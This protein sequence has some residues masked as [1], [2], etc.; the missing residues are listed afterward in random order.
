M[1]STVDKAQQEAISALERLIAEKEREIR[2]IAAA[3]SQL[4]GGSAV[5]VEP[6]A[7]P[8]LGEY[9]GLGIVEAAE[10]WL[11]EVGKPQST[12]ELADALKSRG[13]RTSST[14]PVQAIYSTLSN[15]PKKFR[16]TEDGEW[17]LAASDERESPG[18]QLQ[19]HMH[20]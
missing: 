2:Q 11:S 3:L 6:E 14:R 20:R 1:V 19:Q 4:R 5:I 8:V 13:W 16:R 17:R 9:L 10:R 15:A 7:E 18:V 12:R